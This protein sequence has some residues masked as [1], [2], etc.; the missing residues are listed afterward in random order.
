MGQLWLKEKSDLA[1]VTPLIPAKAAPEQPVS[2]G[3]G[4]LLSLAAC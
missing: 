3:P 4:L 1:K 2:L